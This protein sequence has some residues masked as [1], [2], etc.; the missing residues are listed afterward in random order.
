MQPSLPVQSAP[1]PRPRFQ[2]AREAPI[3]TALVALN[4]I[5]FALEE[6]WGGSHRTET[7]VRMGAIFPPATGLARWAS[8]LAYGYLHVGGLHIGMNMFAL[9]NIGRMLEPSLGSGRFFT[10]YTLSL[11]G[12]GIA[13]QLSPAPHVTAGASGAIFGLMGAICAILWR[14]YRSAR[15]DEERRSIRGS[16]GGL[17]LPNVVISLLPGVSLLGH[18]GG[19]L[20]GAGYYAIS[21][22]TRSERGLPR[23]REGAA[24]AT[25]TAL[26]LAALTLLCIAWLWWALQPWG[27]SSASA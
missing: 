5:V 13:I 2:G 22:G 6:Q 8:M 27:R 16:I 12:G 25:W 23:P 20:V 24:G 11:L 10:L 9:W 21:V 26:L 7:L 1:P 14:R 3:T 4:V 15:H 18:V 17:L 19:L